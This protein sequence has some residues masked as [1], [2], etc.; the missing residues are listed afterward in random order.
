MRDEGETHDYSET[1]SDWSKKDTGNQLPDHQLQWARKLGMG[2]LLAAVFVP[3]D[4]LATLLVM[5][6][7][8]YCCIKVILYARH[9]LTL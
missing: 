5:G 9:R 4:L 1:K 6:T 7:G 2:F 3:F 8:V